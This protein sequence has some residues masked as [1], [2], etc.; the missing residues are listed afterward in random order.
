[1]LFF[2]FNSLDINLLLH[3]CEKTIQD[4]INYPRESPDWWSKDLRIVST[5]KKKL[6]SS[7]L[8]LKCNDSG[9]MAINDKRN[10]AYYWHSGNK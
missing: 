3:S 8:F 10:Q 1:M 9:S 6:E 7:F 5:D 4:E 2:S